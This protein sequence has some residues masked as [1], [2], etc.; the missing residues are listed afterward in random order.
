MNQTCIKNCARN[1][2]EEKI[3]G[4][5][6]RTRNKTCGKHSIQQLF[7]GLIPCAVHLGESP[8]HCSLLRYKAKEGLLE[9]RW[10]RLLPQQP[11][12]CCRPW[13]WRACRCVTSEIRLFWATV[14][15]ER[16]RQDT[17]PFERCYKETLQRGPRRSHCQWY[18]H[19]AER[20]T[21][22]TMYRS[23]TPRKWNQER[24]KYIKK[25]Q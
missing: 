2:Q 6:A 3:R 1:T 12:Y 5:I 13:R 18:A 20:K 17:M 8:N 10:S 16:M 19:G 4:K 9:I 11:A 23:C 24:F 22:S 7:T 14:W 25:I 15:N 21:S